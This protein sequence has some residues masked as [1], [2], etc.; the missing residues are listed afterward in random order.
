ME[1]FIYFQA[2]PTPDGAYDQLSEI[3]RSEDFTQTTTAY[4]ELITIT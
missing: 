4:D 1:I 3:L 2:L